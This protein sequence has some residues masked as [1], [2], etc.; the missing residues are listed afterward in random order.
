M[1]R[2]VLTEVLV[3]IVACMVPPWPPLVQYL[4]IVLN[5]FFYVSVGWAWVSSPIDVLK[6]I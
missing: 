1:W 4:E 3:L 2:I 6:L 5:L